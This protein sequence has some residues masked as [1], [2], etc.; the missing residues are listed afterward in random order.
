MEEYILEKVLNIPVKKI[1]QSAKTTIYEKKLNDGCLNNPTKS[2]SPNQKS[3]ILITVIFPKKAI[4][5]TV[6]CF[7]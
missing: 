1:N 6:I 2:V 5:T 4:K 3:S 7:N